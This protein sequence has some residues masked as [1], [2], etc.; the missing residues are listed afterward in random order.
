M[1]SYQWD[2][3]LLQGNF[4]QVKKYFDD[5]SYII[6]EIDSDPI[7]AS[8]NSSQVS[9]VLTQQ[10]IL[11]IAGDSYCS[12]KAIKSNTTE[13]IYLEE[14]IRLWKID[15]STESRTLKSTIHQF[16][17]T[18]GLLSNRFRTDKSQLRY[19]KSSRQY[20][21]FYTEYLKASI[22]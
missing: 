10:P 11:H 4:S 6:D 17:R 15:L 19:N 9:G 22:K 20:G 3:Y 16:I 13:S 7:R 1:S 21:R 8:L 14:L 5:V 18:T 2:P 12:F